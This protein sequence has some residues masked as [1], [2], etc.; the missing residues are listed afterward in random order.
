[1]SYAIHDM[2]REGD[3]MCVLLAPGF[4]T[5][6]CQHRVHFSSPPASPLPTSRLFHVIPTPMP[7][8]VAGAGRKVYR[9]PAVRRLAAIL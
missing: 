8:Y 3:E 1:M 2:Y 6:S 9:F 4:S 7:E 5:V